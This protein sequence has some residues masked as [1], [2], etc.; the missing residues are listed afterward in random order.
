MQIIV[1][2]IS[3]IHKKQVQGLCHVQSIRLRSVSK[4]SHF[5]HGSDHS[6]ILLSIPKNMAPNRPASSDEL[7]CKLLKLCSGQALFNVLGTRGISRDERQRDLGLQSGSDSIYT[8]YTLS[9]E[10]SGFSYFQSF[11]TV[12]DIIVPKYMWRYVNHESP[13][14][15]ARLKAPSLPSQ[16]PP[17]NAAVPAGPSG[18]RCPQGIKLRTEFMQLSRRKVATGPSVQH[19]THFRAL[20]EAEIF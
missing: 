10:Q 8:I 17:S 14:P 18:G 7:A 3:H 16:L 12:T 5:H 13:R 11:L 4:Q 15:L 19:E 2:F 20:F 9:I 6:I 1:V